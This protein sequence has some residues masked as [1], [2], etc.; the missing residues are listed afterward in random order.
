MT[1]PSPTIRFPSKTFLLGE[2]ITLDGGPCLVLTTPPYFEATIRP[3]Q[4][5]AKI[6]DIP[7]HPE[8]PAGLWAKKHIDFFKNHPVSFF[9][10]HQG[11]GGF[12]ASG[13]QFL[14]VYHAIHPIQKNLT[15]INKLLD[16]YQKLYALQ[17]T[18]LPSGADLVAQIYG[19]ITYWY[20]RENTVSTSVWPFHDLRYS[21][22]RTGQK[23]ATHECLQKLPPAAV[24][25]MSNIVKEGYHALQTKDALRF[26]EAIQNYATWMQKENRL[27]QS[28]Q[29]FIQKLQTSH[30]IRAAKGC[31]AMGADVVLVLV[32]AEKMDAFSSW[33]SKNQLLF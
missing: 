27:L 1:T 24:T 10:P 12:G 5:P 32:D 33:L 14:S 17:N 30:L 18:T 7:F 19:E 20:K 4:N 3:I 28:T 29:H 13:A 9:D 15:F 11:K 6:L 23:Q 2:Y 8:S 31:G 16:D 21:L 26:I 25:Q 22:I